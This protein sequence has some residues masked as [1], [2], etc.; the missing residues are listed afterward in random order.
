MTLRESPDPSEYL[1][2]NSIVNSGQTQGGSVRDP[3]VL[4]NPDYSGSHDWSCDRPLLL[5]QQER[6]MPPT[7]GAGSRVPE[8]GLASSRRQ[9]LLRRQGLSS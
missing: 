7:P 1:D 3:S 9:V 4:P 5:Y 8:R 2:S 6:S